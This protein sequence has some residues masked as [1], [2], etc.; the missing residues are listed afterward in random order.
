MLGK[1]SSESG[2]TLKQDSQ[3]CGGS[4]G[5]KTVGK[6]SQTLCL[7]LGWPCVWPG[8]GFD[9]PYGSLPAHGICD[10]LILCSILVMLI[11]FIFDLLY[12][13]K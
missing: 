6:Y 5:S 8:A 2:R 11:F 12:F 9:N 10:S 7:D 3:G 1:V 13:K 4:W